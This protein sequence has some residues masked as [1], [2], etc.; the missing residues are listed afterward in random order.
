MGKIFSFKSMSR[1]F[2]ST[3][4]KRI[5]LFITDGLFGFFDIIY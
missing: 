1:H 4:N 5:L 3:L 2:N